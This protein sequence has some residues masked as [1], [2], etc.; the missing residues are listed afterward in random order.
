[1]DFSDDDFEIVSSPQAEPASKPEPAP[2]LDDSDFEIVST[3]TTHSTPAPEPQQSHPDIDPIKTVQDWGVHIASGVREVGYNA[4]IGGKPHSK[5]LT[6][7]AMD[8]T[9]GNSGLSWGDLHRRASQ[10]A[11]QW[12][13]GRAIFEGDHVHLQLPGWGGAPIATGSN[14]EHDLEIVSHPD[15]SAPDN[16]TPAPP[17]TPKAAANEQIDHPTTVPIEFSAPEQKV[18][19]PTGSTKVQEIDHGAEALINGMLHAGVPFDQAQAQF[20]ARYPTYGGL[21]GGPKIWDANLRWVKTHPNENRAYVGK[22]VQLGD[23]EQESNNFS[24][25]GTGA[26]IGNWANAA[27]AGAPV[28]LTGNEG[29]AWEQQAFDAH[30]VASW[31]GAIGGGIAGAIA[32]GAAAKA[33]L[34]ALNPATVQGAVDVSMSS[35]YGASE[36]GEGHRLEGAAAGAALGVAGEAV[37]RGVI[38]PAIR[39]VREGADFGGLGGRAYADDVA[40][41][42]TGAEVAPAAVDAAPIESNV[43]RAM[44]DESPKDE[45]IQDMTPTPAGAAG[46]TKEVPLLG[47]SFSRDAGETAAKAEAA[48]PADFVPNGSAAAKDKIANINLDHIE[49]VDDITHALKKA[50]DTFGFDGA[51]RGVISH[52]ET[53]ALAEDL[54]M[55]ADDLLNRREGQALNAEQ[56]YAARNILAKSAEELQLLAR[57]AKDNG[58]AE[59][60]AAFQRALIRHA[61]I[62]E[63]VTGATAEAGRALSAFRISANSGSVREEVLRA[64]VAGKETDLKKIAQDLLDRADNPGDFNR[65]AAEAWK[66]TRLDKA[67]ELYYAGMLSGPQTHMANIVGNTITALT[68][69][70]EHGIAAGIGAVRGGVNKVLGRSTDRVLFSEVG[71]RA[72]GLLQGAKDG[73]EAVSR[74]LR[75]GERLDEFSKI[76]AARHQAIS[77]TKGKIVRAPLAALEVEDEFFKSM[78]RRMEM[79]AQAVRI[80][81][82]EGLRGA[83]AKTRIAELIANPTQKMLA[84]A[85]DYGRYLTF[86]R[87]LTGKLG[88]NL[89]RLVNESP[90]LKLFLPFI[91]TPANIFKY[92]VEHSPLAV[93]M[94]SVWKELAAGGARRDVAVAK[95][96]FGTG[97]A[98][99]AYKGVEDGFITGNGPADPQQK[100]LLVAEGWQP[101]SLKVG[102]RYYSYQRLDP[103]ASI[104]G[105]AADLADKQSGMTEAQRD[106]TTALLIGGM[107]SNLENKSF[108][109]GI[110]DVFSAVDAAGSG[111]PQQAVRIIQQRIAGV[112]VPAIV[113]QTANVLDPVQRTTSEDSFAEGQLDA[114]KNRI[115]GLSKDQNPTRDVMGDPRVTK[116]TLGPDIASPIRTSNATI[117][118]DVEAIRD[119]GA[120]IGRL[121]RR[122]TFGGEKRKLNDKEWDSYQALAGKLTRQYIEEETS[123]ADWKDQS[124]EDRRTAIKSAIKDAR[125]E[126]RTQLFGEGDDGG[127]E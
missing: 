26:L 110:S 68:A 4:A 65:A 96:M 81:R 15:T 62:Q 76:E 40:H 12:P 52:E 106:K 118:P 74:Y 55:T 126:A 120:G 64:A 42:A 54:G 115:P 72:F 61:A 84:Q 100:S 99:A 73:A 127:N 3:P 97:L 39:T 31:T 105:V 34:P 47:T 66:P 69:P 13:G 41:A 103:F 121:Q 111:N 17:P 91:R 38:A 82:G 56:A 2:K 35:L 51:R 88:T 119:S 79:N 50:E 53:Q 122:G 20:N 7:D 33:A 98:M 5:H 29:N 78:A 101:Y 123:A 93:T 43:R 114:I 107:V 32:G 57:V 102:D 11:A 23:G 59:D 108:L 86:Q 113:S 124:A 71:A 36:A 92:S 37:G 77:G 87:Q 28:F 49:S 90:A 63:Q 117:D 22:Q 94:P 60:L 70:I 6:G 18:I 85:G 19:A 16:S 9:P 21:Q 58:G 14:A 8:L 48:N 104:L 25:S 10:I 67:V 83:A 95:V 46:P 112:A 75:T 44:A 45:L 125:S 24:Q 109:T 80:A 89:Q 1:M 30:P 116:E 27:T